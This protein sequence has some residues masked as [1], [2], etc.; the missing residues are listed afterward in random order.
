MIVIVCRGARPGAGKPKKQAKFEQPSSQHTF[1]RIALTNIENQCHQI[2]NDIVS[3]INENVTKQNEFYQLNTNIAYLTNEISTKQ[4]T[5][6]KWNSQHSSLISSMSHLREQCEA[7]K[8]YISDLHHEQMLYRTEINRLRD[9]TYLVRFER[10]FQM[11]FIT[12]IELWIK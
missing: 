6:I 9:E 3:L 5:L 2:S 7:A 11:R 12:S 10:K 1:Q 8:L 4:S